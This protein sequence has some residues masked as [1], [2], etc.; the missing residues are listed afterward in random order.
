MTAFIG[1]TDPIHCIAPYPV[2]LAVPAVEPWFTHPHAPD[3]TAAGASPNAT[4]DDVVPVGIRAILKVPVVVSPA[5][6][7]EI[8]EDVWLWLSS[9]TC[10]LG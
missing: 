7:A 6:S 1:A 4:V 2:G 10:G 8:V 3:L 5:S 9:T